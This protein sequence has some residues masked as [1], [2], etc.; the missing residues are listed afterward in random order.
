MVVEDE[1]DLADMVAYNLTKAG[2]VPIVVHDGIRAVQ[3][4][5]G[6]PPELVVLDL[7]LPGLS[8]LDVARELRGSPATSL[9]PILMLTARSEEGDQVAGLVAGADD[10][11]T[12]PFSMRVLLARVEAL[13]RRVPAQPEGDGQVGSVSFGPI[14]ADLGAHAVT[15]EGVAARLTVTEFRL[16]VALLQSPKRV[17]SRADL[18]ARVMGPGIIVTARTIDVHV[19]SIRKKLGAYGAYIRTIRGVGYQLLADEEATADEA[20]R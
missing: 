9:I 12:K 17:L 14:V 5:Q 19:A 8:G 6:H 16:L 4:A 2:H 3:L 11:V 1:R 18:I 13:L 7:M 20:P 15:V 10:Y